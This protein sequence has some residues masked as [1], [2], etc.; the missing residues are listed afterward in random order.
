L[1]RKGLDRIFLEEI[2]DL[3]LN[4]GMAHNPKDIYY[5]L[6]K[7]YGKPGQS[8]RF[9]KYP[10]ES[11]IRKYMKDFRGGR[12]ALYDQR[13]EFE[14]PTDMGSG[15]NKVPWELARQA[16][17]CLGFYVEHYGKRPSIGLVKRYA[18]TAIAYP[19]IGFEEPTPETPLV[20][21][22]SYQIAI[23]AEKLWYTDL[24]KATPDREP[25]ST[26]YEEIYLAVRKEPKEIDKI[27]KKLGGA[28]R[29]GVPWKDFGFFVFM[30]IYQKAFK[31]GYDQQLKALRGDEQTKKAKERWDEWIES[32]EVFYL[33]GK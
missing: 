31:D 17:D 21:T 20:I 15:E 2:Q 4:H 13:K 8:H 16:L 22:A 33:G 9:C 30:P 29:W 7:K 3:M 27:V 19:I 24:I 18:Q 32:K 23:I 10:G 28:K 26:T 5:A 25:P 1:P 11:T 12:F 14:Y 6:Q